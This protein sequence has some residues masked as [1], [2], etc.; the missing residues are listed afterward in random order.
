MI[1]TCAKDT[2]RSC[3]IRF[4]NFVTSSGNIAIIFL[5]DFSIGN[6]FNVERSVRDDRYYLFS[7]AIKIITDNS[8]EN[9]GIFELEFSAKDMERAKAYVRYHW[10]QI[11]RK[12][13]AKDGYAIYGNLITRINKFQVS[14]TR[15]VVPDEE[16][17]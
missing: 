4:R 1:L 13:Y 7:V 3:D 5:G 6:I 16:E 15:V 8:I 9:T 12:I 14:K 10:N 2:V 17:I 11:C